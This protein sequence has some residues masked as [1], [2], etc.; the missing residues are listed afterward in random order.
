VSK[1]LGGIL[2][3]SWENR[4]SFINSYH[5]DTSKAKKRKDCRDFTKACKGKYAIVTN[6]T[7]SV[8][9]NSATHFGVVC[10]I[11]SSSIPCFDDLLQSAFRANRTQEL[12]QKPLEVHLYIDCKP[13]TQPTQ[14]KPFADFLRASK[15]GQQEAWR[16]AS[17]AQMQEHDLLMQPF[18]RAEV[19]VE[20][21]KMMQIGSGNLRP[22]ILK[23]LKHAGLD[24]RTA[25]PLG[26]PAKVTWNLITCDF[27]TDPTEASINNASDWELYQ[28]FLMDG[29]DTYSFFDTD[30]TGI[31]ETRSGSF[32]RKLFF[33]FRSLRGFLFTISADRCE[34]LRG[35][36]EKGWIKVDKG[37]E[38]KFDSY[39]K[40]Y[41]KMNY[42]YTFMHYI[43]YEKKI[44]ERIEARAHVCGSDH[45]E[46]ITKWGQMEVH[47]SAFKK[48]VKLLCG[49][50]INNL[51]S[52]PDS[53][54]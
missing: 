26:P 31:P 35:K 51:L 20:Q 14:V 12:S 34:V 29:I 53:D 30:V 6:S 9:I 28:M 17:C 8:G 40:N 3:V 11:T 2:P 13:S 4:E 50:A 52:I 7:L 18:I 5:G 43:G 25:G 47:V 37:A 24:V 45:P 33:A 48:L 32:K 19:H 21:H 46:F 42:Y 44:A 27:A 16:R 22:Y 23:K 10:M 15:G 36:F 54:E 49:N 41:G 1:T 39:M 38:K